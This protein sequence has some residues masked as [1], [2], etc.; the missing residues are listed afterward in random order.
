MNIIRLKEDHPTKKQQREF[1]KYDV[2]PILGYKYSNIP[3]KYKAGM[4][5]Y[6]LDVEV[7]RNEFKTHTA[8]Y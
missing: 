2:H 7:S 8:K 1:W 5:S 3:V 6:Q 4:R